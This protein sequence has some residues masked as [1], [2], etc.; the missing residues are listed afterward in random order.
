MYLCCIEDNNVDIYWEAEVLSS[1]A[2][3]PGRFTPHP[4]QRASCTQ[5][6]GDWLVICAYHGLWKGNKFCYP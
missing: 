5:W 6:M 4:P 1:A 2:S 3:R